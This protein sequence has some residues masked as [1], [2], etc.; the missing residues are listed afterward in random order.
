M[1][2]KMRIIQW[3]GNLLFALLLFCF[4]A[5]PTNTLFHL[6]DVSFV[7]LVFYNCLF[8]QARWSR[9]VYFLIGE[10]SILIPW[11]FAV[12][13]GEL[14]DTD[15][16]FILIKSMAPLCLLPWI[17]HYD[18]LRLARWP[19]F[20]S[21]ML[22]LLLFWVIIIVPETETAIYMYMKTTSET[23][24]MSNRYFL[25]V[26]VFCMYHKSTAC[27]LLVF[28]LAVYHCLKQRP[29]PWFSLLIVVVMLHLFAISGTRMTMLFPVLV[30][31]LLVFHF[32]GNKRYY[33]YVLYPMLGLAGLVFV[34][35]LYKL[36]DDVSEPS[37]IV[38]F[39]HL[40]SYK[41]F[42]EE[43]PLFMLV[44]QGPGTRFYSVG[45]HR[46]TLQTEW[47]Y[48]E[49]VRYM[50]MFA[51]GVLFLFFYPIYLL[52]RYRHQSE[53]CYVLLYAYLIYLL[54]A[55][56]NPLLLSS[57]GMFTLLLTYSFLARM[58]ANKV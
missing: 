42:F 14:I 47:T 23:V 7:L 43:H 38:K 48:V 46:M 40:V 6:K 2:D 37:N 54:I 11:L 19:V 21:G 28:A 15:F 32:Y 51:L 13:R 41:D 31:G 56:T 55:G 12:A 3:G 8:F 35:L 52:W 9:L 36:A 45:F 5:D 33:N 20:I 10:L 39:A 1:L 34:I 57:T 26:K 44:G 24:M 16:L 30:L 25:G 50:G 17:H 18:L 53:I 4:A 27:F 49:L 29:F 58:E 22:V